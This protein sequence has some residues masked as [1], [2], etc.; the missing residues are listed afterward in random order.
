[1]E[2][3]E[4]KPGKIK[5]VFKWLFKNTKTCAP[6]WIGWGAIRD[7]YR[8]CKR[9]KE[10]TNRY[11]PARQ[12]ELYR[13]NMRL[14]EEVRRMTFDKVLQKWGI[15]SEEDLTSATLESR[16]SR[17]AGILV[18]LIFGV[19]CGW[20]IFVLDQSA[21][22]RTLHGFAGLSFLLAGTLRWVTA[23]WRLRVF[24]HRAFVPFTYWVSHFG[25]GFE[26]A[27]NAP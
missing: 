12:K 8:D 23:T 22:W 3:N 14:K 26:Q 6:Q 2:N 1:M 16:R 25:N 4:K 20:Q 21:W 9:V 27:G 5:R 11:A 19:L 7:F 10:R 17:L 18:T 13:E 24:Q 15:D